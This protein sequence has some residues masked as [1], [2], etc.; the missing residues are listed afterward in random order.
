MVAAQHDRQPRSRQFGG[1]GLHHGAVPRDHLVQMPVTADRAGPGVGWSLHVAGVDHVHAAR[2][3]R[4]AQPRDTQRI[5]PHAGAAMAGTD[6]GGHADQGHGREDS[7]HGY[8]L[9]KQAHSL[10]GRG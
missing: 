6:I 2:R 4:F 10:C 5:R 9:R 3:Q 8:V 7:T 1:G